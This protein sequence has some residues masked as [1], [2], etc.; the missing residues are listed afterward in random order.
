VNRK[1]LN[2]KFVNKLKSPMNETNLL[3]INEEE[4]AIGPGY[5]D[6]IDSI[7]KK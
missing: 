4:I 3:E 2:K 6:P 5:Y 1:L 7:S